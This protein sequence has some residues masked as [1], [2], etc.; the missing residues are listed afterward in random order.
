MGTAHGA[1]PKPGLKSRPLPRARRLPPVRPE[2]PA[3][4]A[5]ATETV[6][7]PDQSARYMSPVGVV[8]RLWPRPAPCPPPSLPPG[9]CFISG[10][11]APRFP[12]PFAGVIADEGLPCFFHPNKSLES[13]FCR[14]VPPAP[15]GLLVFTPCERGEHA[16]SSSFQGRPGACKPTAGWKPRLQL[17]PSVA[18]RHSLHCMHPRG[19]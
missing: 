7:G 10:C 9:C 4:V 18:S 1:H 6:T 16:S 12:V 5:R 11:S 8:M 15:L 19:R 14:Q 3:L 2:S 17:R 13:S